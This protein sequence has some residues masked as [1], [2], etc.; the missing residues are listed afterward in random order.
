MATPGFKGFRE[1][2]EHIAGLM[3]GVPDGQVSSYE[4][5]I[6]RQCANGVSH[7]PQ[8]PPF[9]GLCESTY[10]AALP[11]VA[12]SSD[13]VREIEELIA[14]WIGESKGAC[15][16]SRAGPDMRHGIYDHFKGG[17]YRS[18]GIWRWASG[19][20]EDVVSYWSVYHQTPHARFAWQWN[21]IVRWPDGR[22]RSRFVYRGPD[23]STP[24]PSFKVPKP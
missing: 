15:M 2:F 20:G 8:Y 23:L 5:D 3:T 6:A 10:G 16:V 11:S 19:D 17:L 12:L 22:W 4:G 13:E 18:E 21:E 14:C 24:E 9:R 7:T 1:I